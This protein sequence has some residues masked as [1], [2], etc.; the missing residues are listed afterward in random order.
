[1]SILL[2]KELLAQIDSQYKEQLLKIDDRA[3]HQTEIIDNK[4]KEL[5]SQKN[6][7][8]ALIFNIERDI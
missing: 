2:L 4:I 3:T 6:K 8:E 1:M 7:I 5:F